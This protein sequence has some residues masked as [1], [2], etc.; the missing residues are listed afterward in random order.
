[1]LHALF[2]ATMPG[3]LLKITNTSPDFSFSFIKEECYCPAQFLPHE[4]LIA[5]TTELHRAATLMYL[6]RAARRLS[7]LPKALRQ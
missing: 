1:M 3:A 4:E 5:T 6:S 2:P 7:I